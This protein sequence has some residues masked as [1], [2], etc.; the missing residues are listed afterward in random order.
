MKSE[1]KYTSLEPNENKIIKLNFVLRGT[2]TELTEVSSSNA[3]CQYAVRF[4]I[5]GFDHTPE[6]IRSVVDCPE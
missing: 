2:D 1:I 4:D 6:E 3:P 5:K